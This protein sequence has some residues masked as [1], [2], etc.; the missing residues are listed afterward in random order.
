LQAAWHE[1]LVSCKLLKRGFERAELLLHFMTDCFGR[2][3]ALQPSLA[4]FYMADRAVHEIR[5]SGYCQLLAVIGAVHACA[6]LV[7]LCCANMFD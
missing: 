4:S 3:C 2:H 6:C 1:E 7:S 5:L